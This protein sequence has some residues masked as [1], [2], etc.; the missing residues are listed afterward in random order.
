MIHAFIF[1][2]SIMLCAQALFSIY[3]M[4]YAWEYPERR[5]C[6]SAPDSFL[7]P[8]FSFTVLLPARHEEAVIY[9]TVQCIWAADYPSHLL[10]IVVICHVDDTGTIAEA[11]RAV[12]DIHSPH[13]RVAT[14][15]RPPINKPHSLNVGLRQTSNQVVT[16]FDAEDDISPD[17]FNLINT[18][19]LTEKVGVIQAGVQLMNFSDH[20]FGVHNCMEYFFWFKSRLHFHANAGCIL[21]GGNTAFIRRDLIEQI[22]GWDE[23][24]LTEDA[25]I[26]L[27]LSSLDTPIR[28]VYDARHTTREETPASVGAFIRQRTRWHQGFLQVLR[29]R[30]WRNLPRLHQRLLALYTLSYP[31]FQALLTLLWP[32]TL[33]AMLALKETTATAII[34]ILPFYS[35]FL[36]FVVNVIG[37]FYFKREYKCKFTFLH[38]F[39]M[40]VTFL[41][42]Q[43]LIGISAVRAVYRELRK[44]NNWEKTEHIGAHR[45]QESLAMV[46]EKSSPGIRH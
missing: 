7:P 2:V 42:F 18:I 8:H 25:E 3:L 35:L 28:V 41:P 21:L 38:F 15:A 10:E 14:F 30:S 16:I 20:W 36:T 43:L 31:C 37:A 44:Q 24:C 19:M 26:G 1:C 4:L 46:V 33:L 11:Q 6:G 40:A 45:E 9:E 17:I 22:G 27:R 13:A 32:L 29:K 34:S 23:R 39:G 5:R 12:E